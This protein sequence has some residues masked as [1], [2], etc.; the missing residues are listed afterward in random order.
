MFFYHIHLAKQENGNSL[1]VKHTPEDSLALK[2]V[3]CISLRNAEHIAVATES[4]QGLVI[5][6]HIFHI[7]DFYKQSQVL[8]CNRDSACTENS[9]CH[10]S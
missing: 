10:L 3:I 9:L 1:E 8:D 2:A 7:M 6:T 4:S 5:H